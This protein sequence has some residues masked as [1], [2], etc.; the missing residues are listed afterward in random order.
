MANVG[1]VRVSSV[2]QNTARQFAAFEDKGIKLEKTFEEKI[3]G[4]NANRP[5][6][7]AMLEY[8]REGDTLY[9]ESMSRLARSASDMLH[10][11]EQL[12]NKGVQLVSMKEAIDTSSPQGQFV[13]TMFAALAELERET[14]RERQ[15]EGL[16]L[17]KA[18]G[19]KLG[20]PKA[21]VSADFPKRYK[22]WKAGRISAVLFMQL[23]GL[24]KATFY[25][26]VKHYEAEQEAKK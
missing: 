14:I 23:E 26:L 4:K 6:L 12:R 10:I 17:C 19:R 5:Q 25:K 18:E 22:E 15:R 8:V 9:I 3:S 1:Y 20:R 16:E 2:G 21:K 7:K 11:A 24:K 13:F